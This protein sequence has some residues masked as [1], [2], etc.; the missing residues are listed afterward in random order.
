MEKG[1]KCNSARKAQSYNF[2][3]LRFYQQEVKVSG[4]W[5][6]RSASGQ[7]IMK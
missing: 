2:E 5:F 6:W 3:N 4:G 1:G 7:Y